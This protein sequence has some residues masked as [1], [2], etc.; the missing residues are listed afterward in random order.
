MCEERLANTGNQGAV[1]VCHPLA[2]TD[3]SVLAGLLLVL[4][5]LLPDLSEIG[6]PGFLSLKRQ[7]SQQ[8]SKLED[9]AARL[10]SF[11]SQLAQ[12]MESQQTVTQNADPRAIAT[13]VNVYDFN[14]LLQRAEAKAPNLFTTAHEFTH[15]TIPAAQAQLEI[16]LLRI[17]ARLEAPIAQAQQLDRRNELDQR[18]A[19]ALV[20]TLLHEEKN[21][22]IELD[23]LSQRGNVSAAALQNVR[24]REAEVMQVRR[25][26]EAELLELSDPTDI[27]KG[28]AWRWCR[29]FQQE[30]EVVRAA[31][32]A[33]I[34]AE[35]I[36]DNKLSA[37]VRLAEGLLEAWKGRIHSSSKASEGASD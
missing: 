25:Q 30:I 20:N 21:I 2:V 36:E 35:F 11:Q 22:G 4:L 3:A 16:R 5:L 29:D 15:E 10:A 1:R 19:E 31:R 14:A 28:P 9:Q 17:W 7:V 32:D 13:N 18:N 23:A 27:E 6:I 26:A 12:A 8:E 34:R 24:R 37:A 33:V